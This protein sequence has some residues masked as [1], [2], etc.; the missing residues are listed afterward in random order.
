MKGFNNKSLGKYG[1]ELA[2][3]LLEA[4]GYGIVEKNFKNKIG[5]IDLI[6][7]D[8]DVIVFVEVKSRLDFSYGMPYESVNYFKQKKLIQLALSYLKFRYNS[9]DISSRFDVVSVYWNEG[10]E[11]QTNHII[12]AF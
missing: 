12:N 10:G 1:E 4:K 7:K 3:S 5:E 9:I 6:A 2:Q 8:G 11:F